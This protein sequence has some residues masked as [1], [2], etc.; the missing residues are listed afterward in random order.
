M[1]RRD[2]IKTAGITVVATAGIASVTNAHCKTTSDYISWRE[3]NRV[4]ESYGFGT[5]ELLFTLNDPAD[6]SVHYRKNTEDGSHYT[7]GFNRISDF[8]GNK[9]TYVW[10]E[11]NEPLGINHDFGGGFTCSPLGRGILDP[12][13]WEEE[14]RSMI[15]GSLVQGGDAE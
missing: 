15:Y 13:V 8:K 4:T 1:K 2:F 5:K 12:V 6:E 10:M 7:L 9:Y 11:K 14:L 3:I